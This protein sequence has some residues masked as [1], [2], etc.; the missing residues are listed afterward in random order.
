MGRAPQPR[1]HGSVSRTTEL[2]AGHCWGR[3]W[4]A[5]PA[6]TLRV[7]S[8]LRRRVLLGQKQEFVGRALVAGDGD[9]DRHFPG[10]A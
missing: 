6:K 7:L 10:L 4:R 3:I 1:G 5:D 8:R 2:S 9:E